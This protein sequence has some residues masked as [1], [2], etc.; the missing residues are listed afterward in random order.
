MANRKAV[1]KQTDI[2]RVQKATT[3]AGLEIERVEVSENG[4]LRVFI[5]RDSIGET[6]NDWDV[7]LGIR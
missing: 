7:T 2:S 6:A 1:I 3:S 4:D 5:S